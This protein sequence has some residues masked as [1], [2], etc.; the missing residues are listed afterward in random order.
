MALTRKHVAIFLTAASFLLAQFIFELI[1]VYLLFYF[2]NRHLSF[3]FYK[4]FVF[5]AVVHFLISLVLIIAAR[6]FALKFYKEK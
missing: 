6:P 1:V 5:V 4:F 2:F 3:Y